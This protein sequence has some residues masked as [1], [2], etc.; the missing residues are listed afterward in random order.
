MSAELAPVVAKI[1]ADTTGLEAGVQRSTTATAGLEKQVR[2]TEQALADLG[3]EGL[4]TIQNLGASAE[5]LTRI[6]ESDWN[7]ALA[8]NVQHMRGVREEIE[9]TVTAVDQIKEGLGEMG[10]SFAIATLA[11]GAMEK[12]VETVKEFVAESIRAAQA[13]QDIDV[14]FRLAFGN[15]SKEAK[16]WAEQTGAAVGRSADDLEKA[17]TKFKVMADG[18][19][20]TG[21]EAEHMSES[22]AKLAV[23]MS[24]ARGV[25]LEQAVQALS[26]GLHGAGRGLYEFGIAMNQVTQNEEAMRLGLGD[27]YSKLGEA[28]AAQVNFNLMMKSAALVSAE[29]AAA[30]GTYTNKLAELKSNFEELQG[31]L[32]GGVLD[33]LTKLVSAINEGV[34]AY[35]KI[36]EATKGWSTTLLEGP[37]AATTRAARELSD[38]LLKLAGIGGGPDAAKSAATDAAM[39]KQAQE[40]KRHWD[41]EAAH[42]AERAQRN[43]K[44][45]DEIEKK[46]DEIDKRHLEMVRQAIAEQAKAAAELA[47]DGAYQHNLALD[48]IKAM[49]KA[50]ADKDAASVF[51]ANEDLQG[52]MAAADVRRKSDEDSEKRAE[53]Q[54]QRLQKTLDDIKKNGGGFDQIKA[55]QAAVDAAYLKVQAAGAQVINDDKT[56]LS[57]LAQ[58]IKDQ[59]ALQEGRDKSS[60]VYID[61]QKKIDDLEKQRGEAQQKLNE[62]ANALE[63][64]RR[65]NIDRLQ[66]VQQEAS[67]YFKSIGSSLGHAALGQAGGIV[68]SAAQ[69]GQVAGPAGAAAGAAVGLMEHSRQMQ[70]LQAEVNK[71]T[72]ALA[73][74]IGSALEPLI[75]VIQEIE[76]AIQP[77]LD[78]LKPLLR[79]LGESVA[80]ALQEALSQLEP[81]IGPLVE[82]IQAI[83]PLIEIFEKVNAIVTEVAALFDPMTYAMKA[84]AAAA[85]PLADAL[86]ATADAIGYAWDEII[87]AVQWLLNGLAH[88]LPGDLG[89]AMRELDDQLD[90]LK[91]S[92]QKTADAMT[93]AI[94]ALD[95]G[96]KSLTDAQHAAVQARIN[97]DRQE[98]A[99]LGGYIG[100]ALQAEAER[101]QKE[102]DATAKFGSAM[103]LTERHL[104]QL[105]KQAKDAGDALR[106]MTA[107]AD[108]AADRASSTVSNDMQNS[109]ALQAAIALARQEGAS[110]D[111]IAELQKEYDAAQAQLAID[112][113]KLQVA[114]DAQ[115]I[116]HDDAQAQLAEL[117]EQNDL[118]RVQLDYQ[119]GLKDSDKQVIA[120]WAAA[121]ADSTAHNQYENAAKN[122]ATQMQKDQQALLIAQAQQLVDNT[123]ATLGNTKAVQDASGSS[124]NVPAMFKVA[125]AVDA[126][127]SA[128]GGTSSS[129]KGLATLSPSAKSTIDQRVSKV[130]ENGTYNGFVNHGTINF[131][132]SDG[133]KSSSGSFTDQVVKAIKKD[134]QTRKGSSSREDGPRWHFKDVG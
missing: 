81:F 131:Y 19:G 25:P 115:Q 100:A 41:D 2:D 18:M 86:Q 69:G 59:Q 62:D 58:G 54:A 70:Q 39:I 64:K 9:E 30:S 105:Q 122:D 94:Q 12:V 15:A 103:D 91:Y 72:Q 93:A 33:D 5:Q 83:T 71:L 128:G 13:A 29:A 11:A 109:A 52:A 22:L 85:G 45:F 3:Q 65:A 28:E 118:A 40:Q 134:K 127:L 120:D 80:G 129:G 10:K 56:A 106:Q 38:E 121:F 57:T 66:K 102:L 101:L 97:F 112:Q 133:S 95:D 75:P 31:H 92:A 124:L 27:T 4:Q 6:I 82:T 49:Q 63:D 125:Q 43:A 107:A 36:N 88:A 23:Q 114:I 111:V 117:A 130:L 98:A 79:A 42:D 46:T 53:S 20:L 50:D 87:G 32:A 47:K 44:L 89:D 37:I 78:A 16:E 67:N 76:Q 35:D 104:E 14:Q 34:V 1:T 113:L 51:S 68:D 17:A 126:A 132:G 60:K 123:K 26:A 84:L 24:Q 48:A 73:D 61:A 96:A 116:A 7:A 90:G 99:A 55:A 110:P 119:R 74:T 108:S 21:E 8:E 77:V